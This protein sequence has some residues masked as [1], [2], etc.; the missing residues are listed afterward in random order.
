METICISLGGHVVFRK[1]GVN[2]NYIKK[3]LKLI[4]DYIGV[5]KFIIVVGGGYASRLYTQPAREV[6]K[7]NEVLDEIAI[8]I[9]RIN[10]LIVKD[11]FSDLK[12]YPNVATSLDELRAAT[13]DSEVVLMGGLLPGMTTDAV[14]VLA[15]EVVNSRVMMNIGNGSYVYDRP[16]SQKG[17]KRLELL[18]HNKL[19]EIAAKYDTREADTTFIFDLVASKLAKRANIEIRF[20][21]DD[22]AQLRLAMLNE[23]YKGS[24]VKD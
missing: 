24:A 22:I 15:S 7:N 20:V 13:R 5:Y 21:N 19:V 11:I 10:A 14:A 8:A 16:P 3:L 6:I 4:K 2:V 12:V 1:N 23:K 9:T 17:A 18:D